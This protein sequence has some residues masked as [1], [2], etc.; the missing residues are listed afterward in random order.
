MQV[1]WI[2]YPNTTGMCRIDYRISDARADPPDCAQQYTEALVRLPETFLCYTPAANV[3]APSPPPLLQCAVIT[4]G[5]FNNLAKMDDSV[6]DL[7]CEVL[8]SVPNSRLIVKNKPFACKRV[9]DQFTARFVRR[10][11]SDSR[12]DLMHLLPVTSDHLSAY[13][14]IDIS[15]D[16]FPYAGTTTTCEALY[17]GVPVVTL[18]GRS[19]AHNVGAS[20][21]SV[22]GLGELVASSTQEYVQ[23][24]V[25]LS[26]D[27][28]RLQALRSSL[29]QRMLASPLCDGPLL[30]GHLEDAY[31]DMWHKWVQK[32]AKSEANNAAVAEGG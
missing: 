27:A 10:G 21:L 20:L 22:I 8:C 14:L 11:I 18:R 25:E 3:P 5:S 4:F 26:R 7:W 31:R 17:M 16:T 15:L 32:G 29:R 12:I 28:P 30:I 1:S 19:H 24:A 13:S 9:Q 2:G 23:I 6:I